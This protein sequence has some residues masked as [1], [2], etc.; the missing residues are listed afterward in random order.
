MDKKPT[1]Y[2][3]ASEMGAVHHGPAVYTRALWDLFHDGGNVDFHLIVLKSDIEHPRIHVPPTDSGKRRGFYQRLETHIKNSVPDDPTSFLLHVN[4]AHLIS[5]ALAARYRT[6]VQINDTEVCQHK[7]TWTGIRKHG[8]RRMIA[9]QWRKMRERAVTANSTLV[10]GNSDFTTRKVRE[11]YGIDEDK[12]FRV[13]KAVPLEP[14]LSQFPES[15][16]PDHLKLLFIGNNW[17]RK[18]LEVLIEAVGILTQE[19]PQ[20]PIELDIYGNPS[21]ADANKFRQL[22]I[23]N[24]VNDKIRFAGVLHRDDA[25]LAIARSGMLVLPSFEEA[26]GLVSI[27]AIATGIPVVGSNVG[28]I[29][30][31]IDDRRLGTLVEVGN[32]HALA[33]AIFE[34][35]HERSGDTEIN[36]RKESSGRFA[37]RRL[38]QNIESVYQK[39]GVTSDR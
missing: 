9:L 30:E 12:T 35:L 21:H 19:H 37:I 39:Y 4:A 7:I 5:G 23:T 18:G 29:P 28:G 24:G 22:A 27:E 33:G 26:L 25:P 8:L 14:F 13:Y 11:S 1:V 34:Q 32:S 3:V 6:I 31:V 20:L 38:R 36:F 16:G 15:K 17:Q 2:F 10:I